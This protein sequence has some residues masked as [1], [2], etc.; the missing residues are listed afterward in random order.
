MSEVACGYRAYKYNVR[1]NKSNDIGIRNVDCAEFQI[2]GD[3]EGQLE[4]MLAVPGKRHSM[5]A[6]CVPMVERRT[7]SR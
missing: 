6:S 2:F 5:R 4:S 7:Y 1:R 3:S